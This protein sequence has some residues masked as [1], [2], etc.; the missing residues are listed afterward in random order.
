MPLR[1]IYPLARLLIVIGVFDSAVV[2]VV[3]VVVHVRLVRARTV[4][5][6]RVVV[7]GPGLASQGS[8]V[9]LQRREFCA[10][11]VGGPVKL[12]IDSNH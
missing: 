10:L 11:R 4:R 5:S 7:H 8:G 6:L 3:P 1:L 2:V 9:Q 12:V